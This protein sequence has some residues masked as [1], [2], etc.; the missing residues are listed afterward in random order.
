MPVSRSP[1]QY[2]LWA[3]LSSQNTHLRR[4][5][6]AHWAA[7]FILVLCLFLM[8][9]RPLMAIRVNDIGK[10]D[11]LDAVAPTNV[12]GPEEAEHVSRLLSSYLLEMT[13]GAVAR[14]LSRAVS[15]MTQAF[16]RAY[17]EKVK[18]D[19][20]LATIEKGNVRT[21][22][23][24]E[25]KLTEIKAQRDKDGRVSRY[26]VQMYG[27]VDVFRADVLTQPLLTRNLHVRS[28]LLTVP[29][30]S[31]TLNGLLVDFFEAEYSEPQ[32]GPSI[33]SVS[34]PVPPSPAPASTQENP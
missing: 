21:Q 26:F 10:A 5:N 2:E 19:P 11:L 14:D 29:R 8:A 6:W 15:L 24:W 12:P 32:K 16:G 4:N 28:T 31:Q 18:D 23:T 13:S 25:P 33:N 22:L 7:H 20:M 9:Q 17:R 30:T 34:P 27:R 3:D 1:D